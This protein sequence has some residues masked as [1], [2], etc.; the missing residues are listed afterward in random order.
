[1]TC[2]G[3]QDV[4]G[5]DISVYYTRI[6]RMQICQRLGYVKN[7]PE[8]EHVNL[9]SP[10]SSAHY[11]GFFRWVGLDVRDEVGIFDVG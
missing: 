11:T 10:G 5:F 6:E 7:L 8:P 3:N 4:L 1:M 2:T 9:Q